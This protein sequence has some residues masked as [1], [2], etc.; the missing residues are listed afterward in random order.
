[1][2]NNFPLVSLISDVDWPTAVPEP[3][4]VPDFPEDTEARIFLSRGLRRERD[5]S[6]QTTP[7]E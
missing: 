7:G 5:G 3:V 6:Y 4:R 2:M 1:M